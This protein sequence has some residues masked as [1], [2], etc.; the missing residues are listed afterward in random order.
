MTLIESICLGHSVDF[1]QEDSKIVGDIGEV[2]VKG[3]FCGQLSK[4]YW[5]SIKDGIDFFGNTFEVKTQARMTKDNTLSVELKQSEKCLNVDRL[6]FVEYD[7]TKFIKI[8]QCIDINNHVQYRTQYRKDM[9][10]WYIKDMISLAV[11]SSV[12]LTNLIRKH[13]R[14]QYNY[15]PLRGLILNED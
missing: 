8:W 1:T 14:A 2:L 12:P 6:I 11:I 3:T 7:N 5:D 10:K 13:S 15:E 9:I 4:D